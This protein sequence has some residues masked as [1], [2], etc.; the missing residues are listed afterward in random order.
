MRRLNL[1]GTDLTVSSVCL[2]A[3]PVGSAIDPDTSYRML[4]AFL[5]QGGNF[6]D[7]ALVYA[8]W[9]P[10][11]ESISEKTLGRWMTLRGN[12]GRVVIGTKGA[13]PDLA[14]MHIPRMSR[15]D[16]DHDVEAS[17]RHLQ[18][19]CIDLYW[20]HRDDPARPAGEIVESL[21]A[22]IQAGR[23]CA[24]GCSNWRAPRIREANAYAAAHGL[25][26]FVADQMMWS[27]AVVDPEAIPDKTL[28]A[29]DGE[30]HAFHRQ[31]SMAA[32]PYS[33][34][35]NGLFQKMAAGAPG[36]SKAY[37]AAPN[38]ARFS[39]MQRLARER[40]LSVSQVVLAYLQSQP[41]V[42]IPIVGCRTPAQLADSLAAA[43]ARLGPEDIA[44]LEGAG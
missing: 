6:L 4:D 12:R 41:F 23:I 13:H 21:N 18:V 5:D 24:V 33:S 20:L 43:D 29:M 44:F 14:A 35:A 19:D 39:R 42:T 25:R 26:G 11:E 30:L 32:V 16:I 9:L 40:G 3:G 36:A 28:V 22:H 38:Q 7:T 34:Q 31:S 8:N 10:I 27:A 2:G 1:P 15:R 17:R 37:P